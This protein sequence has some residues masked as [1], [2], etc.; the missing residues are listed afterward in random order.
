MEF[1]KDC[2]NVQSSNLNQICCL[3]G[4]IFLSSMVRSYPGC[5]NYTINSICQDIHTRTNDNIIFGD[6]TALSI[7]P[8]ST[9]LTKLIDVY[10]RFK[11]LN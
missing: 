6:P 5:S 4:S 2:S 11:H 10:Q 9:W 7:E 8:L 3:L 1:K